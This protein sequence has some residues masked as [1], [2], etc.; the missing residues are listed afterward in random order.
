MVRVRLT[1]GQREVLLRADKP[2][3]MVA[4]G[5]RREVSAGGTVVLEQDGADVVVKIG[6]TVGQRSRDTV[7]FTSPGFISVGSRIYRGEIRAFILKNTGMVVVNHLPLDEYLYGVVPAEIGPINTNTYQAV[8]AQAVAARS[9]TLARLG[10]RQGL[11]YDLY[12]TYLR[13]QEYRGA[14]GEVSLANQAV[15]ETR[16]EVLYYH[17]GP[18]MVLYHACCGGV[19][20]DG[21]EPFLVSVMDTPGHRR[22]VPFCVHSRNYNWELTIKKDSL[23][24]ALGRLKFAGAKV[25]VRSFRLEKDRT[26][27]RVRKIHFVTAR[28]TVAVG[29][30]EFRM[31]LGLKSTYF[32]M[33]MG[34]GK[35][36]FTGKGWGHGV[37]LCQDG[38]IAMAQ[39]GYTYRQILAHYYPRLR[40]K[41]VY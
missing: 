2:L 38:A 19:T 3:T 28:G 41:K 23:E 30:S 31:A 4:G 29:G 18:A 16:G 6:E 39:R 11:G 24:R 10:R 17:D 7:R 13:D 15:D 37:G 22:G 12:D 25:A 27:K 32:D 40:L 9:F 8:K 21:S 33:R 35:V 1:V 26:G 20:A 34:S 14:G 36:K 5:V